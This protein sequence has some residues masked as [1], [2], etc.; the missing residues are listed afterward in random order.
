MRSTSQSALLVELVA[1]S[2]LAMLATEATSVLTL[3]LESCMQMRQHRVVQLRS[4]RIDL[5][6][7]DH[8]FRKTVSQ[9]VAGELGIHATRLQVEQL[10]LVDLAH[11]SAVRALHVV[12]VDLQLRLRIDSRLRRQQQVL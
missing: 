1:G 5:D 6:L 10:F 4:N 7:A 9:E 8:F 2:E 12:G 3:R 11:R